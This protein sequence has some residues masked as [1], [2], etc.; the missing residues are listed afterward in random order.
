MTKLNILSFFA[1]STSFRIYHQCPTLIFAVSLCSSYGAKGGIIC[2][3]TFFCLKQK[4][5]HY[6]SM[7]C[8]NTV[9]R[10]ILRIEYTFQKRLLRAHSTQ[11]MWGIYTDRAPVGQELFKGNDQIGCF[12][13]I[14]AVEGGTLFV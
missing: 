1:H 6:H 12:A 13:R 8:I 10:Y 11:I 5:E 9:K 3:D 2:V 7:E 14:I 4:S